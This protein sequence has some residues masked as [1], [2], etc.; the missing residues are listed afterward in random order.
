MPLGDF[1]V[2]RS[3][4]CNLALND[5][6]VSR[7]HAIIRV[8]EDSLSVEDLG[9]RNGV[10]VNGKK[11]RKT[12]KLKH[13][14][15][16]TI[17]NQELV[18]LL[19]DIETKEQTVQF[20]RCWACG[21]VSSRNAAHCYQCGASLRQRSETLE[22]NQVLLENHPPFSAS[23]EDD[24]TQTTSS[25]TLLAPIA[26]KALAL[27][28]FEEASRLL[29]PSLD[30]LKQ[31]TESGEIIDDASFHH[32]VQLALRVAQGPTVAGRWLPW[33][34]EIHTLTKRSMSSTTIDSLHELVRRARYSNPQPLRVYLRV[35]R[36]IDLPP[37]QR[38]LVR[39]LEA[40]ER[41]ITA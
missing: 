27:R 16:I 31:R 33:I 24:A 11:V 4:S 14:D 26:E 28:R 12:A 17:G 3:S 30:R 38:F 10:S 21:A 13:M 39:R 41:V 22:S 34:F 32:G 20:A 19:S 23:S 2:G 36:Q 29:G 35:L 9:S 25:F 15:R 8:T 18:V 37:A 6:L 5:G 7:R 40:L 1:V